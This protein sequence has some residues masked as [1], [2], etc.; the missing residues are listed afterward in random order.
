MPS[1]LVTTAL[2]APSSNGELAITRSTADESITNGISLVMMLFST[3]MGRT[4]AV[5]PMMASMLKILLPTVLPT[6]SPALPSMAEITLIT[7]SGAEVP[8]AT[9]VRPTIRSDMPMRRATADEPS[10]R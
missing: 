10:V 7:S 1:T 8:N 2:G 6:A 5:I 9:T 3:L 4:M